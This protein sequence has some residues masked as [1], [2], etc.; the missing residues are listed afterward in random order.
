MNYI[1]ILHTVLRK[2]IKMEEI[3]KHYLLYP[4]EELLGNIKKLYIDRFKQFKK[5]N[6][7]Y[8]G[9]YEKNL[10]EKGSDMLFDL[11]VMDIVKGEEISK[12]ELLTSICLRESPYSTHN[13]EKTLND[14]WDVDFYEYGGNLVSENMK[15]ISTVKQQMLMGLSQVENSAD[16]I[17]GLTEFAIPIGDEYFSFIQTG[18]EILYSDYIRKYEDPKLFTIVDRTIRD[19]RDDDVRTCFINMIARPH[20]SHIYGI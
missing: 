7:E 3:K 14:F 5:K 2:K 10:V 9:Q 8:V 4:E 6:P 11:V 1:L 17:D 16:K 12:Y 19:Y 20:L 18:L 15:D 13:I